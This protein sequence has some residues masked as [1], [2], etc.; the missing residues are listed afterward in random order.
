MMIAPEPHMG[1][2]SRV[3]FRTEER[4][5]LLRSDLHCRYRELIQTKPSPLC[6]L[7]LR[8]S[9]KPRHDVALRRYQQPPERSLP[10]HIFLTKRPGTLL[11]LFAIARTSRCC[12]VPSACSLIGGHRQ[13]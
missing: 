4:A 8:V 9:R 3:L 6:L 1:D 7:K 11:K 2:S 13:R 5:G 12:T 10:S